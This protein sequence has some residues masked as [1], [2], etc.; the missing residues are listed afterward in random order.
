MADL[1]LME[2]LRVLI[3]AGPTYEPLDPVRFIGNHSTGKMGYALAETFAAAGAVVDLISGPTSLPDPASSSIRVQRVQTADEMYAAAAA[4]AAAADVWV[5]AAA[6]ADYKP[7]QV[8]E[9]KIKKAGD[10]LT[11]ELVKN[12]DIAA[13]LGKTKRPEQ[14]SVGFALETNNERAHAL[15]KLQR[16]NFDLVVLNS[17]RDPGAGFRH[18]TNKVTLLGA[19]GAVTTFELKPKTEVAH[20]IVRTV[21]ARL[22]HHA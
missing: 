21:L 1:F 12:V 3:T 8:A 15:E 7:A 13:T 5:F 11:L 22:P 16:K 14:F 18:D 6:V 10:T 20:D 4:V 2:T 19:D 17:L 9:N